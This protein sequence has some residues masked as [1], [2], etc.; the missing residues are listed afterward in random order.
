MELLVLCT[1]IV[2][3]LSGIELADDDL[4]ELREDLLGVEGK[5]IDMYR[6]GRM[7]RPSRR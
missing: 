5:G 6:D 2:G 4:L 7:F 3:E 1:Q